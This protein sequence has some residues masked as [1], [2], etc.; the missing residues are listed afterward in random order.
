MKKKPTYKLNTSV[1]EGILEI[2][3]TDNLITK[4]VE[5]YKLD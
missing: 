2:V 5:G 4:D 3:L 1:K